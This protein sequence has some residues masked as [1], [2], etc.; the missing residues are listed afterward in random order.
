MK[1][2]FTIKWLCC[3]KRANSCQLLN[4]KAYPTEKGCNSKIKLKSNC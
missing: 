4:L 1:Y 3:N 2:L